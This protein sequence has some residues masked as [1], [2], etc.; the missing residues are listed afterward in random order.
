M[1]KENKVE[2]L[3]DNYIL[4]AHPFPQMEGELLLFQVNRK[5]EEEEEDEEENEENEEAPR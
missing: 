3:D 2:Q 4:A 1:P 5:D